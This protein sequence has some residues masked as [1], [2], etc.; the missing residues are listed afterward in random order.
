MDPVHVK[1]NYDAAQPPIF[2]DGCQVMVHL[3]GERPERVMLLAIHLSPFPESDGS[4]I[5]TVVGKWVMPFEAAKQFVKEMQEKLA[6]VE[7]EAVGSNG[8]Q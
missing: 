5:G 8:G 7:R 3:L 6:S 2:I 1:V 4:R